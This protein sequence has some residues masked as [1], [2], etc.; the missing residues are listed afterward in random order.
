MDERKPSVLAEFSIVPMGLGN[1]S[2]GNTGL[3]NTGLGN[4]SLGNTGLGNTSV[5]P[6]VARALKAIGEVPG[7]NTSSPQWE[8]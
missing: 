2:L 1:T 7:I 5:G 3:G 8:P 6:W 4:T